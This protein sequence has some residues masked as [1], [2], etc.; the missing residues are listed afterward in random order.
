MKR[1][2]VRDRERMVELSTLDFLRILEAERR[3]KSAD[4]V[5]EL[6]DKAGRSLFRAEKMPGHDDATRAAIRDLVRTRDS[7]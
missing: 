2:A 6:A 7:N 4:H 3:I 1:I 5:F